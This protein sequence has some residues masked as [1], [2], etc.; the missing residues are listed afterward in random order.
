MGSAFSAFILG[1][2]FSGLIYYFKG[3]HDG[4]GERDRV[5]TNIQGEVIETF[6]QVCRESVDD[7]DPEP[8]LDDLGY[9]EKEMKLIREHMAELYESVKTMSYQDK[10]REHDEFIAKFGEHIPAANKSFKRDNR[11]HFEESIES[12]IRIR[13]ALTHLECIS[14]YG[15]RVADVE[16]WM[17][18]YSEF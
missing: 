15:A 2:V 1:A 8:E 13:T 17:G 12:L 18:E 3:E 7:L 4:A 6:D 16:I 11:T 5:E 10:R 9:S 14:N